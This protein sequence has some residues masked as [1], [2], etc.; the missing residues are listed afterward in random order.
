[1]ALGSPAFFLGDVYAV[2]GLEEKGRGCEDYRGSGS[3]G[4][5]EKGKLTFLQNLLDSRKWARLVT[6]VC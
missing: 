4:N 6:S 3:S 1:M 2:G 5:Q